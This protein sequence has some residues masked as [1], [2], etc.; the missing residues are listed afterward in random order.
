MPPRF[1]RFVSDFFSDLRR[2]VSYR[3]VLGVDIGTVSIKMAEV[4]RLGDQ[5]VL[6]N[7]GVLETKEYLERGNAALQTGSLR[8]VPRDASAYLATLLEE[9]RPTTRFAVAS[10][11]SFAAFLVPIEIPLLSP[12]ETERLISFQARQYIPMPVE[13]VNIEWAK[14]GEFD[15]PRGA[16][17]QRLLVTAI[18]TAT[19]K[20]YQD[21][22]R[23]VG[24]RVVGIE[25]EASALARALLSPTAPATLIVDLG[26]ESTTLVVAERGVVKQVTQTDY[27]GATLSQAVARTFGVSLWRAEELKRRR[28][29]IGSATEYDL[30]T[31]LAPFLDVIIQECVRAKVNYEKTATGT[32]DELM[33]VGGT[34]NLPGIR[35]YFA[36]QMHLAVQTPSPLAAIRY[37]GALEPTIRVL[38]NELP[39]ALGLAEK[40]I[41]AGGA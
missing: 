40:L 36:A 23:S 4:H 5:M 32:V 15:S 3:E 13:R 20:T 22:F 2:F 6:K 30:S 35:D 34:A 11:P 18:P 19:I 27:G 29:L 16:R 12:E 1:F 33:L 31:S 14:V 10:L 41:A 37:P 25:L 26:G 28:G 24:L 39:V 38:G 21:L 9:V 7:Y 17:Y 8:L